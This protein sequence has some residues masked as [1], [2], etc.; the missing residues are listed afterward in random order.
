MYLCCIIRRLGYGVC[1]HPVC[2][3]PTLPAAPPL[4][5]AHGL[6]SRSC[7]HRAN[8]NSVP[9]CNRMLILLLF[10]ERDRSSSSQH[11]PLSK[12][13][14]SAQIIL[15]AQPVSCS[16]AVVALSSTRYD[17]TL[18][19]VPPWMFLTQTSAEHSNRREASS[20]ACHA[21]HVRPQ[22]R[23]HESPANGTPQR[24]MNNL[25]LYTLHTCKLF[26]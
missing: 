9:P 22:H 25:V 5:P 16:A 20:A 14:Q 4:P 12:R 19:F 8:A 1:Q 6:S 10:H 15:S 7:V 21:T 17:P 11:T 2:T 23:L 13:W 18:L 3:A 26:V 24:R